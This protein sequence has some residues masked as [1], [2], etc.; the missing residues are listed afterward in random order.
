[1]RLLLA[2]LAEAAVSSS[3]SSFSSEDRETPPSFDLPTLCRLTGALGRLRLA[4]RDEFADAEVTRQIVEA[5][6][7]RAERDAEIHAETWQAVTVGHSPGVPL[8]IRSVSDPGG[9]LSLLAL[10]LNSLGKLW[11]VKE[12]EPWLADCGQRVV[13]TVV[14]VVSRWATDSRQGV[15]MEE[16]RVLSLRPDDCDAGV[17]VESVE[18]EGTEQAGRAR[19]GNAIQ[20]QN[21]DLRVGEPGFTSSVEACGSMSPLLSSN[22]LSRLVL[23]MRTFGGFLTAGATEEADVGAGGGK[24]RGGCL[25]SPE[26]KATLQVLGVW[27]RQVTRSQGQR[28]V[29]AKA[30][31]RAA[32]V[33]AF[34]EMGLGLSDP[35]LMISLLSACLGKSLSLLRP[36]GLCLLVRGIRALAFSGAPRVLLEESRGDGEPLVFKPS[37][38][39]STS[40]SSAG[41]R[42]RKRAVTE[43]AE[44]EGMSSLSTAEEE[45]SSEEETH[46]ID[47]SL[48]SHSSSAAAVSVEMLEEALETLGPQ[49]RRRLPA[50]ACAALFETLGALAD[51][52]S[53]GLQVH[54]DLDIQTKQV[55]IDK[56]PWVTAE[57]LLSLENHIAPAFGLSHNETKEILR[58]LERRRQLDE[59]NM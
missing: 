37:P 57:Q 51:M 44:G 48:L 33:F 14:S 49:L 25:D 15:R 46:R 23:G 32:M 16:E 42:K 19:G 54:F 3:S 2:S 45:K 10:L 11:V 27:A 21:G 43:T 7:A 36:D 5:A 26:G 52:R 47:T 1:M 53:S 40:N 12:G 6:V 24:K 28:K 38:S 13:I 9:F 59:S 56:G 8:G 41:E 29:E 4:Y 35:H 17:G 58:R 55:V 30:W 50:F 18:K 34:S 31:E 20:R 39:S 22:E